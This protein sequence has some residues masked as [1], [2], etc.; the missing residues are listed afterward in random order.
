MIWDTPA[1]AT[2]QVFNAIDML[3][4]I[5][6]AERPALYYESDPITSRVI[7]HHPSKAATIGW[8]VGRGALH[9]VVT[10][11]LINNDAPVWVRATWQIITINTEVTAVSNNYSIGLKIKF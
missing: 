5:D 8:C 6:I 4:S 7:G 10:W 9:G 1:E 3:Q 2:Y 11:A